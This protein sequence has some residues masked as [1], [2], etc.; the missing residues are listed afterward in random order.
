MNTHP[1]THRPLLT[2]GAI[3]LAAATL[4]GCASSQS[5]SSYGRT[6]TRQEMN[7][8]L[9]V[10]ESVRPVTI[11]GSQ[12]PVGT[13]GGAAIG[14]IA[15]SNMGKGKGSSVGAVLG[16]VL[17]GMA[18]Q[19]AEE[20]MTKKEGIEI[21][22]KLDNGQMIAVVQEADELFRP[23]DKVRVLSNGGQSRVSH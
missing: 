14:G 19:A 15:G 10:V 1:L 5:G 18:G 2:L 6:V 11:E 20:S 17:G 3:V 16:A 8:R 23:G 7:V 21:T 13:I 12:S 22:V 9:G 4:A